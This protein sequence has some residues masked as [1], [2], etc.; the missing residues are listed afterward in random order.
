MLY[1]LDETLG[2]GETS[3]VSLMTNADRMGY[4]IFYNALFANVMKRPECR[5]YYI[6]YY[7]SLVNCY[8]SEERAVPIMEEMHESHA[9]ELRYLYNN[10]DL[11]EGNV[12]TP[13]NVD[14]NHALSELEKIRYFL[15]NRPK[16]AYQDLS[17]AFGLGETY[18]LFISNNNEDNVSVD[19]ATFYDKE[20][21]GKYYEEIPVMISVTPKCG[22]KFD[23]WLVNGIV[24]EDA[25]FW[26]SA[27]MIEEGIVSIECVSSP[28]PE[29]D[30]YVTAFKSNG[31]NDY[32]E[33]TNFGQNT[34]NL[35]DF[36]LSDGPKNWN[37]SSLPALEVGA[38]ESIKIYCKS[39]TGVEAIGE[40]GVGF[41]LKEGEMVNLYRSNGELLQSVPVPKLSTKESV[42]RINIHNGVFSEQLM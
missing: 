10:T 6:R 5:E 2:F 8:C 41:N 39:Y 21:S 17:M 38:G 35:R 18:E 13:E 37:S 19:F 15:T 3:D 20:F 22:Y 31:G 7:L 9:D 29:V 27:D 16:Y 33:L 25:R 26:I 32:V 24:V 12:S 4:D 36:F 14:Y 30:L 40:P 1:D 34:V 11:L 23:Y 28:D 42:Y